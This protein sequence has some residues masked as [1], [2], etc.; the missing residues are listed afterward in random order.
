MIYRGSTMA[1]FSSFLRTDLMVSTSICL[2]LLAFL[3]SLEADGRHIKAMPLTTT[4]KSWV[5]TEAAF[6][7]SGGSSRTSSPMLRTAVTRAKEE[8]TQEVFKW[9]VAVFIVRRRW[10][11]LAQRQFSSQTE[12]FFSCLFNNT[13]HL[14]KLAMWLSIGTKDHESKHVCYAQKKSPAAFPLNSI[15]HVLLQRWC[16]VRTHTHHAFCEINIFPQNMTKFFSWV[17]ISASFCKMATKMNEFEQLQLFGRGAPFSIILLLCTIPWLP[18]TQHCSS[19]I[20]LRCILNA[21]TKN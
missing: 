8:M 1:W 13:H 5:N 3:P 10:M 7:S 9:F 4:D 2:I 20:A 19:S 18:C 16:T 15:V 12:P 17:P 11:H 6:D 14:V 21:T